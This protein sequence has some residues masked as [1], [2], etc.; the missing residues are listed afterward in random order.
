MRKLTSEVINRLAIY[1]SVLRELT[2]ENRE[3]VLSSELSTYLD[4][5]DS[6]VRRD[7]SILNCDGVRRK[8][9]PVLNLKK[10]T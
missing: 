10:K 7:L 9:Y 6:Q 8:G 4:I 2:L 1:Y 5:D 3:Y